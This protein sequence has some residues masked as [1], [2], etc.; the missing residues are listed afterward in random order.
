MFGKN[1]FSKYYNLIHKAPPTEK[2]TWFVRVMSNSSMYSK[3]P[4][5]DPKLIG[6]EISSFLI[7]LLN[8]ITLK[9]LPK[10][11]T[12]PKLIV[13]LMIFLAIIDLM[14]GVEGIFRYIYIIG[15]NTSYPIFCKL[16]VFFLHVFCGSSIVIMSTLTLVKFCTIA[17]PF[18]YS[19]L[20]KYGKFVCILIVIYIISLSF[21][22]LIRNVVEYDQSSRICQYIYQF[23]VSSIIICFTALIFPLCVTIISDIGLFLI[24]KRHASRIIALNVSSIGSLPKERTAAHHWKTIKTILVMHLGFL[25]SWSPYLLSVVVLRIITK[26]LFRPIHYFSTLLA[27]SNSFWNPIIYLFTVKE[28]KKRVTVM[29]YKKN[30]PRIISDMSASYN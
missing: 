13:R 20:E 9:I 23:N 29:L 12:L 5:Y 30:D 4:F 14:V 16:D 10:I 27:L 7:L 2:K 11:R 17:A 1:L 6:Y 3:I 18:K 19:F 26:Q 25:I 24:T 15:F 8:G 21:E 28:F 22:I